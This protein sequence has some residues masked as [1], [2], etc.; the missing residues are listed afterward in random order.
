MGLYTGFLRYIGN[1]KGLYICTRNTEMG[2]L[3]YPRIRL[4][5][6]A[7]EYGSGTIKGHAVSFNELRGKCRHE[8]LS[9][10]GIAV[11]PAMNEL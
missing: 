2:Q 4:S 3:V 9:V 7:S 1:S 11:L 10:V 6:N 5:L 8:G